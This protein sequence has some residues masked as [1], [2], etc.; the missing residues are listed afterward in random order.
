MPTGCTA[1]TTRRIGKLPVRHRETIDE[2]TLYVGR[3]VARV[4]VEAA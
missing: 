4:P 1:A 3:L 2:E